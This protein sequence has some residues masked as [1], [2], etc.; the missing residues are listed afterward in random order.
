VKYSLENSYFFISQQMTIGRGSAMKGFQLRAIGFFLFLTSLIVTSCFEQNDDTSSRLPDTG[1]VTA[2]TDSFGEDSDYTINPPSY[3][4][5]GSSGQVLRDSATKWAMIR[6]NVT[7]L[8]WE[9]K[10]D[11]GTIHDKD[12]R[13]TWYDPN[14]E[15][16]GGDPDTQDFIEALN[17]GNFGGYS[18][19]RLPTV[20]ELSWI[21]HSDIPYP[22]PAIN[23]TYFPNIEPVESL[24][25]SSTKTS[26]DSAL[27][28]DFKYGFVYS[29]ILISVQVE[30]NN[31]WPSS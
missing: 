14:D 26:D 2:Y 20:Q 3:T 15:T 6:D 4:K 21:L 13:Y 24:S 17:E 23:T 19:W 31:P 10:T 7:G 11:D 1:Q 27:G 12:N 28:V 5:L 29:L 25:W 30:T 18:D 16:N 9:N 22:G 8:V